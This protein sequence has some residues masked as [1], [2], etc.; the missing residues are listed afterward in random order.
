M[1][2]RIRVC[3]LG[4]YFP[5]ASGGMETHVRVLAQGQAA[6]GADVTVV[7]VN[8]RD[9]SGADVTWRR[10]ARTA[11]AHEQDGPVRV[12]RAGRIASVAKLDVCPSLFRILANIRRDGI[13][14]LH[15]HTP[16]PTALLT[17]AAWGRSIPLVVTH[18]SDVVRQRVLGLAL[19]PFERLVYGRARLAL[20]TSPEYASGSPLLHRFLDRVRPLPLGIDL[21]PYI[22][23]T[24]A[25]LKHADLIRC[26]H[27]GPIWLS[28]GRLV[29]YK[30]LDNAVRA[31]PHVP[32]T[33]MVVGTGPLERRLRDLAQEIGVA[34][35]V[36]WCGKLGDDELAGAYR[37][38]TALW[39]P[40]NARSEGFGLVQVE[41]MA[42][43][44]AVINS[45][46]PHSGVAWVCRHER[47][48]LTVLLN[49][50][51]ALAAAARRL[52][53][54]PGIRDRLAAA[55][56]DRAIREFDYRTMAA[57]SL[58]IYAEA[59]GTSRRCEAVSI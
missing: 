29:Y 24:D 56:R 22:T 51:L 58:D 20:T 49:D 28:I 6:L 43:G 34:D 31:L 11:T 53:D 16:N 50:P 32:G 21:N 57:R 15:L 2:Q 26:R 25:A 54:E 7:C 41:A 37:A 35:R 12:F 8:H 44:C 45:P 13:D 42:S 4:K 23:P 46:V 18:H 38:A 48:G 47:E 14:L 5:P 33:L 40:S 1:E 19:R 39:F 3:H 27:L 36:V 55:G 59:L 30:G 52:L 10:F 9:S 17:L